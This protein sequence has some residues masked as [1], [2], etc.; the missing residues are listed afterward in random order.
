MQVLQD[1]RPSR[2][3]DPADYPALI[4]G[5]TATGEEDVTS[6]AMFSVADTG[7][8]TDE[9]R[10][11]ADLESAIDAILASPEYQDARLASA[12][13]AK[14]AEIEGVFAGKIA[15]GYATTVG[16]SA[17]VLQIREIDQSN[18]LT[19]SNRYRDAIAAGDGGVTGA[20]IR[21]EANVNHAVTFDEAAAVIAAMSAYG[22]DL[23]RNRW[24]L[25]D[26]VAAAPDVE[27]VDAIDAGSGWPA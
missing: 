1:P 25:K 27:T 3:F 4:A 2:P 10:Y 14:R 12:K 8:G 24:D 7:Q 23:F 16:G 13:T 9:L 17:A 6:V 21:D 5:L 15:A 22:A 20:M 19:S 18:W 11:P 26:Q